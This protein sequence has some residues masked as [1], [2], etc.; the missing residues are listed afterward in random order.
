MGYD[1]DV[2]RTGREALEALVQRPY[3]L[4]LMDCQMP[5]M[6]GFEATAH[7]RNNDRRLGTHTTIVALTAHA[8][9]GDRE[10][11]LAA[12]MDDYLTKPIDREVLRTTLEKWGCKPLS[13][14]TDAAPGNVSQEVPFVQQFDTPP[15]HFPIAHK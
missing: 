13:T 14:T 7:I 9:N 2:V 6:D 10:R 15:H 4:V 11:C 5:E 3:Q 1:V 12:G 8:I